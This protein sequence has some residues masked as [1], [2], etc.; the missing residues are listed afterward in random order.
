MDLAEVFI[1]EVDAAHQEVHQSALQYKISIKLI[2]SHFIDPASYPCE[3][4][5]LLDLHER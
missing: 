4:L 3:H 5:D 2:S 1:R